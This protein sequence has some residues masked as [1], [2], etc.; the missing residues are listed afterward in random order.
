MSDSRQEIYPNST[1]TGESFLIYMSSLVLLI[2][3]TGLWFQEAVA[4]IFNTCRIPQPNCDSLSPQ[5]PT[6]VPNSRKLL[7]MVN[8]W[9]YAIE[10]YDE[11]RS[12]LAVDIIEQHLRS[13]VQDATWRIQSGEK[14][15]PVGILGAD[16]R[17]RWTEVCLIHLHAS[18]R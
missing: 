7:V 4:K 15:V 14:A 5:P 6:Y 11:N 17:D 18:T 1:R 9:T 16:H 12:L 2:F 3:R 8:D 10:A 13:V